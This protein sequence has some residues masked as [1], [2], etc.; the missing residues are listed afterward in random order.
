MILGTPKPFTGKQDRHATTRLWALSCLRR[1][2]RVFGNGRD[3]AAWWQGLSSHH[4]ASLDGSDHR[5][6]VHAI[7]VSHGHKALFGTQAVNQ[8]SLSP[9]ENSVRE[10]GKV[11][12]YPQ[13]IDA[14][15]K[16]RHDVTRANRS[17]HSHDSVCQLFNPHDRTH[18][19][20]GI[21]QSQSEGRYYCTKLDAGGGILEASPDL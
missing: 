16:R 20:L 4:R 14:L 3:P 11:A 21:G 6:F 12:E 9:A 1:Q 5:R 13:Q 2:A 8:P 18:L 10:N 15:K 19:I 7:S 17:L